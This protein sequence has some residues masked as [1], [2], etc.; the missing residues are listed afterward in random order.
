MTKNVYTTPAIT[1]V[2]MEIGNII[3]ASFGE[4]TDDGTRGEVNLSDTPS[5]TGASNARIGGRQ[6]FDDWSDDEVEE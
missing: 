2:D 4:Y 5:T 3:A 1:V 6:Y